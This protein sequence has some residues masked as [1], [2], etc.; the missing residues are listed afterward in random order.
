MSSSEDTT[1]YQVVIN[2]E[3]QYSIWPADRDLPAGW[4]A[5]GTRGE[6]AQCLAHI[7]EVW[8]DMRPLSL[9]VAMERQAAAPVAAG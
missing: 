4:R 3:E 8:T 9:R 2:D 6:K 1:V 5:D 7:D